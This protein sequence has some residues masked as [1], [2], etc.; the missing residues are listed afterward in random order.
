MPLASPASDLEGLFSG[1]AA[2]L[3]LEL[4]EYGQACAVLALQV[5]PDHLNQAG[6]LHGGVI[7]AMAD[8][9]LGLCGTWNI[10]PA[11]WRLSLTLSLN[12]N[13]IAPAPAGSRV[14]A[15]ARVR[16]GGPKIYMAA[17]DVLD[18]EDNLLASAEGVF[19][20]SRLRCLPT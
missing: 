17:C 15:I 10:D 3:G 11:L 1:F 5:R 20:R 19:K 16:G 14:R 6:N 13:Y 7:A 9:A 12:I 2:Y 4:L 18:A 8:S